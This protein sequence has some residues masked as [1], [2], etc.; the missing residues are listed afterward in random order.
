M[1]NS[2][3]SSQ[4]FKVARHFQF[5][6]GVNVESITANKTLDYKSSMF[7]VLDPDAAR[8]VVL[9]AEKDGAVFFIKNESASYA[10]TVKDDGASTIATIAAD[11]G[12]IVVCDG[13]DWKLVIKA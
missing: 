7:Q 8:D 6:N 11:E 1:A 10:L 12:A 13:S 5:K 4:A 3:N 9:P 2:Y